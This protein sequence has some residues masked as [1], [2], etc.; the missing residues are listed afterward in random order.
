VKILV[1]MLLWCLAPSVWASQTHS[2]D[3]TTGAETWST[4]VEGVTFA[5]TQILPDQA[6]AF[7]LNRGF[8]EDAAESFA[9]A[10]V[11]MTVLRNDNAPGA[12]HYKL[13]DWLVESSAGSSPP[14]SLEH[15]GERLAPFELAASAKLAFRWAQFP[16]E[17]SYRPG[18]D[19]NQGMLTT[20]LA[21][22]RQFDLVARWNI[23]DETYKARLS[24]VRCAT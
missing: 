18:G 9:T 12:I 24:G 1:A 8:G 13:A 14:L 17:Q 21:A 11:F 22:G 23:D 4:T 3:A 7:Y 19:W 15:W 6:R 5:V 20:G 10:C 2:V 16:P